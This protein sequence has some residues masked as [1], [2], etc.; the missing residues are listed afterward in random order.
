M[1]GA[2]AAHVD[3]QRL[4]RPRSIAVFGGRAAAEVIRQNRRLGFDGE[5]WPVHPR[6]EEIEGQK[7]YRSVADLPRAPDAA[8]LG[9]N[10]HL[11]VEVIA[12]LAAR[13]AGGAVAYASGFAETGG[14]G[15]DLQTQL[16]KAAGAMP[17]LGP[18]C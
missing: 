15:P 11:T 14:V 12:A 4:L 17:F 8:F 5:I 18:N 3:L 13:G 10:R 2:R 6:R 16:V 7:A 1:H 9:I